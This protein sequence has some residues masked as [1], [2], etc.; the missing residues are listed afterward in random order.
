MKIIGFSSKFENNYAGYKY[1]FAEFIHQLD[2]KLYDV[3][4]FYLN[5][6]FYNK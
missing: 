4:E 6:F 5:P 2:G 1:G 3:R